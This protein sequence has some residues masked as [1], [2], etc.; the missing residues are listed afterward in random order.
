MLG[1]PQDE[2]QI[3]GLTPGRGKHVPS[4]QVTNNVPKKGHWK[5]DESIVGLTQKAGH[6]MRAPRQIGNLRKRRL[7]KRS[8]ARQTRPTRRARVQLHKPISRAGKEIAAHAS[9]EQGQP[10]S[11]DLL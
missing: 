8:D 11:K 10:A 9:W 7:Q 6:A 1:Q 2:T 3:Q 5:A 4:R